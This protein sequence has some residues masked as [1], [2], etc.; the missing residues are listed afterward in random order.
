MIPFLALQAQIHDIKQGQKLVYNTIKDGDIHNNKGVCYE[1]KND[2]LRFL[3]KV[4]NTKSND[5]KMR[6][7]N[8]SY[9][10]SIKYR[11]CVT[12]SNKNL[13]YS[14][15]RANPQEERG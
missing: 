1:Y 14:G 5:L 13:I 7:I 10:F 9:Q 12:V 4:N 8:I 3:N 6:F 11:D 15:F 2:A